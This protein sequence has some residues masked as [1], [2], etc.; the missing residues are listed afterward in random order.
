MTL[1]SDNIL[2]CKKN[3]RSQDANALWYLGQYLQIPC[4]FV[5]TMH[6][7]IETWR[8]YDIQAFVDREGISTNFPFRFLRIIYGIN[9]FIFL[10]TISI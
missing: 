9:L 4:L 3:F 2:V 5:P 6:Q 10:S 7:Y 8:I 1:L